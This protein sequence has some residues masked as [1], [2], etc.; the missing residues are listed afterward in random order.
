V[1]IVGHN[2]GLE[3]LVRVL[4]EEYHALGTAALIELDLPIDCWSD[5]DATIAA[6]IVET[7]QPSAGR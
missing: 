1:L 2:P 5:L 3:E 6:S 7:W 4:T